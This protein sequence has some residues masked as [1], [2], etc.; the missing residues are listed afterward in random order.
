MLHSLYLQCLN[1]GK[2][3]FPFYSLNAIFRATRTGWIFSIRG[4]ICR[5][6]S[7]LYFSSATHFS[8]P[9]DPASNWAHTAQAHNYSPCT[10]IGEWSLLVNLTLL[11]RSFPLSPFLTRPHL[12]L[13]LSL[14][15]C[16]CP[17]Y[18]LLCCLFSSFFFIS[19]I[20]VSHPNFFYFSFCAC[21]SLLPFYRF[22]VPLSLFTFLSNAYSFITFLLHR[23]MNSS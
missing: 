4:C 12:V 11:L 13:T 22:S 9:L 3:S 14:S 6:G 21:F 5:L 19:N 8:P 20:R 17:C 2:Y 16:Y 10:R 7:K 15:S 18:S 23:C 1:T